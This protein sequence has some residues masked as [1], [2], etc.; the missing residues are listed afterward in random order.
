MNRDHNGQPEFPND[1]CREVAEAVSAKI[2][3]LREQLIPP[4]LADALDISDIEAEFEKAIEKSRETQPT[5]GAVT[6]T[7]PQPIFGEGFGGEAP[8]PEEMLD[9]MHQMMQGLPLKLMEGMVRT[10]K[11]CNRQIEQSFVRLEGTI[12]GLETAERLLVLAE[13]DKEVLERYSDVRQAHLIHES[14]LSDTKAVIEAASTAINRARSVQQNGGTGF[15]QMMGGFMPGGGSPFDFFGEED[16][17]D[18]DGENGPTGEAP[19]GNPG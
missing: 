1:L 3:A 17:S 16:D 11:A 19:G 12:W 14:Y 10:A 2:A 15:L 6:E 4:S 18:G 8:I 5:D 7:E 13:G 9:K